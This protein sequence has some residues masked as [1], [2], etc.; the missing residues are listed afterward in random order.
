M[1]LF[2]AS[3]SSFVVATRIDNMQTIIS[4]HVLLLTLNGTLTIIRFAT[5]QD[6]H[7]SSNHSGK[8]EH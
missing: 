5:K 3:A 2:F 7:E 8:V 4:T 1:Q 6:E